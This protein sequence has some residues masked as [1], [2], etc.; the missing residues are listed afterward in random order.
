[1]LEPLV[2]FNLSF[3]LPDWPTPVYVAIAG[4]AIILLSC[5]KLVVKGIFSLVV[6]FAS[7]FVDF[8]YA[9]LPRMGGALGSALLANSVAWWGFCLALNATAKDPSAWIGVVAIAAF[10]AF[11]NWVIFCTAADY[12]DKIR[13]KKRLA[14]NTD[15]DTERLLTS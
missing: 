12:G 7:G 13:R 2:E 3:S 11:V 8:C 15:A 10:A 9:G 5:I 1:M 6:G 4:A 14:K